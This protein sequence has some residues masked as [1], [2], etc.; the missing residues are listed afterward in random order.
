MTRADD[1]VPAGRSGLESLQA[2][3][4]SR[5]PFPSMGQTLGF[6]L[7]EVA[8]GRALFEG[9]A[10]DHLLNPMGGV[11]GGFALALIDSATGCALMS[12][13]PPATGW[14][15]VETKTNFLRPIRADSGLVRCEGRVIS[16]GRTIALADAT[17]TLADGTLVAH[18]TST[19]MILAPRGK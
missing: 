12:T 18:G 17:V 16:R 3:V 10:G 14:T 7:I 4:D 9:L 1:P 11:H 15:T 19:L 5:H 6:R 13:L 8:E 2:I